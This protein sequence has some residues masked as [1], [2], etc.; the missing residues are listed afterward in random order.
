MHLVGGPFDDKEL[1]CSRGLLALSFPSTVFD[2]ETM[3][4]TPDS[5]GK[6]SNFVDYYK[7]DFSNHVF[8]FRAGFEDLEE[9]PF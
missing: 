7:S 9:C 2:T 5:E 8:E 4:G 6:A 3:Q 1:V